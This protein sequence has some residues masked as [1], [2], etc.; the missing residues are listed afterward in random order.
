MTPAPSPAPA[1][2]MC[3]GSVRSGDYGV[4]V[5][6]TGPDD[7]VAVLSTPLECEATFACVP[8]GECGPRTKLGAAV[9]IDLAVIRLIRPWRARSVRQPIS[10]R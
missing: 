8:V 1:S 4:S 2:G 3:S 6:A 5:V 10:P 9:A 7:A